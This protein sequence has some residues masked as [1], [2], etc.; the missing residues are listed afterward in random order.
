MKSLLL[1]AASVALLGSP[2][3][4]APAAQTAQ[5]APH[6]EV[7]PA[8]L[9]RGADVPDPHVEGRVIHDGS[10][11]LAF[12]ASR[13]TLLGTSGDRYVVHLARRDG[14]GSRVIWIR[15]DE[16]ERVLV[17]GVSA[18]DT[19]LSR[20]GKDLVLTPRVTRRNTLVRVL[21]ARSGKEVASRTFP[22]TAS[23]L[24]ADESRAVLG[25]WSPNRTFWWSYRSGSTRVVSHRVGYFADIRADR[26][27]SY[28]R[29]PYRGGCSVLTDLR[30][31]PRRLSRSC[32]ERVTA[33]SPDGRRIATIP[34]LTDGL[35]P[36]SIGVRRASGGAPLVTYET[37]GWFG[38]VR[39]ED[40]TSL[41]MDTYGPRQWATVRGQ[42]E[43]L[44]R[45]SRLFDTP[46]V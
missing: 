12:R 5:T 19:M 38:R 33:V 37:R 25:T 21:D 40:D 41:L 36:D 24:D 27:A 16:T 9:D 22:G 20:D 10:T 35:G 44:E 31:T 17:R 13:V 4:A 28:T 6:V 32:D 23:V 15:A 30:A 45:A 3:T 42:L 43:H 11:R 1:A 18:E 2:S 39:W 7:R 46:A 29:D 14:S 34:I 8:A 26:L